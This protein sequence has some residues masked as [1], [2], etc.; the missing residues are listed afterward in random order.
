MLH[1]A[2]WPSLLLLA[3]AA[4]LLGSIPF[5][6][7]VGILVK[8]VD[9]RKV[10]SGNI[11]AANAMRNL[12][13]VLGVVT[14]L[15][16]AFKGYLPV[17]L[18]GRMFSLL[19]TPHSPS[20]A[21]AEVVVGLFAIVGHNNSIYLGFKGGKGIAT[22]FGVV[23]AINTGATLVAALAWV[24]GFALTRY[25]SVG[26]LSAAVSIPIYL[27]FARAPTPHVVFGMLACI[28]AFVRHRSNIKNLLSGRELRVTK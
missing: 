3:G 20:P 13:P 22:M 26:S 19:A 17:T 21:M 2:S 6:L 9:L 4:F 7:V 11:G 25:S 10:G 18:A 5:G 8:G 14:L 15:L 24:T 28:L 1:S 12:G 16:D 27:M 23:L